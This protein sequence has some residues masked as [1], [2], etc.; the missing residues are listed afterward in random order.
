VADAF[1]RAAA[2]GHDASQMVN[3]RR[4]ESGTNA[5]WV[6]VCSCGWRS[7]PRGRKVVTASAAYFHVLEVGQVLDERRELDG[8]EWSAAPRTP[9]LR[10]LGAEALAHGAPDTTRRHSA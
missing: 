6:A 8:V 3:V 2:V 10:S 4:G 1:A 5:G 9:A 7:T